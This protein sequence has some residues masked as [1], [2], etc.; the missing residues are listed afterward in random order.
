MTDISHILGGTA[1]YDSHCGVNA[2][3]AVYADCLPHERAAGAT[4]YRTAHRF[5]KKVAA[6]T[7]KDFRTVCAVLARISPQVSW[8]DNKTAALEICSAA[9][10]GAAAARCYPDNVHRAEDIAAEDSSAAIAREV[11]PTA[12]YKRS[13]ISAFYRNIAEPADPQSVT[14]DTWA[15]RIWCEDCAAPALRISLAEST[16]IADDYRSAA[17]IAGY[18]PQELQAIVWIGA[19]RIAKD[20]GQRSLFNAGLQFKV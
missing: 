12:K 16:R 13:K 5:A 7:G 8:A 15:A 1:A 4:W 14:V 19:H 20:R 9:G 18:L 17:A 3:L 2:I 6:V 11:L 10:A